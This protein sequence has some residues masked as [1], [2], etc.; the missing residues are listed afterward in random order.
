[1][2]M[3]SAFDYIDNEHSYSKGE[4]SP[5]MLNSH[6]CV[7]NQPE[8]SRLLSQVHCSDSDCEILSSNDEEEEDEEI[9]EEDVLGG[10]RIVELSVLAA[11]LEAGCKNCSAELKLSSCIGEI[12]YGLGS[13]LKISCSQCQETNNIPT[14]KRHGTNVWD[15]NTKLGAA[16]LFCGQGEMIIN[17]F[18]AALNIP[19]V[20][21]VTFKR[22]EREVGSSFEAVA[23]ETCN[24]ALNEEKQRSQDAD[25]N[26][27][28]FDAGWQTRGSGRNYASL[29]GHA[30][31]IGQKTGKVLSYAVRCKKCRICDQTS[32]TG[33]SLEKDHDCRK[34]W[35]KSSKAMESDMAIEMLHDLK[36]RD[37]HVK[38]LIMDNDSTTLAKAK[39]SF[40]PNIQ[41]IS[42][43]NHT[44]KT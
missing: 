11:K 25:D 14:G 44:K 12:R 13:L 30:S 19:T 36:T 32:T 20:T 10:R 29:T 22:R 31:M 1:M 43:F 27:V 18:L 6:E 40:D 26:A 21:P 2:Q 5:C 8:Q 23:N 33:T 7:G 24:E 35:T 41:K 4:K 9:E 15:I 37:F 34:N 3:D 42:D 28:S 38:N 16:A 17:N 39:L